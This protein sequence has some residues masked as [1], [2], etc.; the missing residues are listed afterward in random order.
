MRF[1]INESWLKEGFF[2]LFLKNFQN[3]S[4]NQSIYLNSLMIDILIVKM[5]GG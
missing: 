4:T 3:L 5:K 2:S 1:P